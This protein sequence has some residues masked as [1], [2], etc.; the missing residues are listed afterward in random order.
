MKIIFQTDSSGVWSKRI[1]EVNQQ[2]RKAEAEKNNMA[3]NLQAAEKE[4][5]S[6]KSRLQELESA[7]TGN[8]TVSKELEQKLKVRFMS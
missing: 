7:L 2:L 1:D 3:K 6:V 5:S 4:C 8:D